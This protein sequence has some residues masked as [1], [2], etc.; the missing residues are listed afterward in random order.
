MFV[1]L[2]FFSLSLFTFCEECV[3]ANVVSPWPVVVGGELPFVGLPCVGGRE[4]IRVSPS[5]SAGLLSCLPV[6]RSPRLSPRPSE[7]TGRF[8]GWW[9]GLLGILQ[10]PAM[11]SV[12]ALTDLPGGGLSASSAT[13][14]S[15]SYVVF[16]LSAFCVWTPPG[17]RD[18]CCEYC[19]EWAVHWTHRGLS[20]M[21]RAHWHL[22][23]CFLWHSPKFQDARK[24][25]TCLLFRLHLLYLNLQRR[26]TAGSEPHRTGW[27]GGH[28]AAWRGE[29]HWGRG[30]E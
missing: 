3:H 13:F 15:S 9:V 12:S 20:P 14:L 18:T 26:L 10:P 2:F 29:G 22:P 16:E 4:S 17:V 8:Q 7:Q 28:W 23:L 27:G 30:T 11:P 6:C 21:D 1:F 25:C 24:Q 5:A 19:S